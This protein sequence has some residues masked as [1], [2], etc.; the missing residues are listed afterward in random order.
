MH[1]ILTCHVG[2]QFAHQTVGQAVDPAVHLHRLAACPG[3]AQHGGLAH[4]EGLFDHVELAQAIV[5]Q[6]DVVDLSQAL[7]VFVANILHMA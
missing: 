7:T 2:T 5:A 4:V 3:V 6:R 1:F